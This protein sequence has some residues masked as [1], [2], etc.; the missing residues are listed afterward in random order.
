MSHFSRFLST[1]R[2]AHPEFGPTGRQKSHIFSVFCLLL[3][4]RALN[5]DQPVD[6]N[7]TFPPFFVYRPSRFKEG[8]GQ[9]SDFWNL[10]VKVS[11]RLRAKRRFLKF[12]RKCLPDFK[13]SVKPR[14]FKALISAQALYFLEASCKTRSHIQMKI[15]RTTKSDRVAL[16][17]H[18]NYLNARPNELRCSKEA[19]DYEFRIRTMD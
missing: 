3:V 14:G 13:G 12:S 15:S 4:S 1:F 9:N 10:P 6:K 17:A 2:S 7:R 8:Y 19:A 18:A 5:L 11:S 16:K